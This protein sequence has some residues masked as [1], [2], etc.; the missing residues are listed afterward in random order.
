MGWHTFLTLSRSLLAS[1]LALTD[2]R[3]S[4]L[5]VNWGGRSLVFVRERMGTWGLWVK[6]KHRDRY[7]EIEQSL[8]EARHNEVWEVLSFRIVVLRG[9][10]SMMDFR[11][12][13]GWKMLPTASAL[14]K[15]SSHK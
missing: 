15:R 6:I 13:K 7:L 12:R 10:S 5:A 14:C 8:L 9:G 1:L 11:L 3:F 2:C 4:C